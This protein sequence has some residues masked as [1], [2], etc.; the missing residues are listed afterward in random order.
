MQQ[1]PSV[2]WLD[3][4]TACNNGTGLTSIVIIV[5]T[6]G[7][8]GQMAVTVLQ[9]LS[10]TLPT[11]SRPCLLYHYLS[12]SRYRIPDVWNGNSKWYHYEAIP[13]AMMGLQ[14][15]VMTVQTTGI[16]LQQQ[17]LVVGQSFGTSIG[18]GISAGI[19]TAQINA[20]MLGQGAQL[21]AQAN[22]NPML[23]MGIGIQFG[24]G[25]G[26]GIGTGIP[27]VQSNAMML[28]QGAQPAASTSLNPGMSIGIGSVW[29]WN[30]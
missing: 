11:I 22:L 25:I 3:K 12:A 23:S 27:T 9:S 30:I 8:S 28:G 19:P 5:T 17:G 26:M 4:P 20:M 16:M 18:T 29:R 1:M 10:T 24:Q 14:Q 15:L 6:S 2:R 13:I 21:A 7:T